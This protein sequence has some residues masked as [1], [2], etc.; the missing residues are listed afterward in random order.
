[1]YA[2]ACNH[3][4]NVI[5]KKKYKKILVLHISKQRVHSKDSYETEVVYKPHKSDS[6]DTFQSNALLC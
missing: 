4:Q 2:A 6:D 3:L 5:S 1:M